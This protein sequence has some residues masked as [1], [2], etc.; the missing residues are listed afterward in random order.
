MADLARQ[1]A[2]A[3]DHAQHRCIG[4]DAIGHSWA[5]DQAT[6]IVRPII[7]KALAEA[8]ALAPPD[9]GSRG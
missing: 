5:C 9:A 4:S 3:I 6:E 7:T 1:I 2:H 8:A